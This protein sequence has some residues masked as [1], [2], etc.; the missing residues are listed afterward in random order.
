MG[1]DC[2][3]RRRRKRDSV[4]V[5]KVDAYEC[6]CCGDIVNANN[7]SHLINSLHWVVV[8][9]S[10]SKGEIKPDHYCADCSSNGVGPLG[11]E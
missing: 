3:V 1:R 2:E 5:S 6:D 4:T 8:R 7:E 11:H 9:W 10:P